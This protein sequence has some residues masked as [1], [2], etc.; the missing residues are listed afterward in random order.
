M[1]T[2]WSSRAISCGRAG[3]YRCLRP[4]VR[5]AGGGPPELVS[6]GHRNPGHGGNHI[7]LTRCPREGASGLVNPPELA[8][9]GTSCQ[10]SIRDA[11]GVSI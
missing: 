9:A 6:M 5:V 4:T 8:V 7:P 1:P 11:L 2:P 3:V 10:L